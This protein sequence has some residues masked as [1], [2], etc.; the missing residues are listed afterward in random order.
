MLEQQCSE[1]LFAM[2]T[3]VAVMFGFF[4]CFLFSRGSRSSESKY[5]LCTFLKTYQNENV[6]NPCLFPCFVK[7]P[8][9]GWCCVLI[10]RF[11]QP[12]DSFNDHVTHAGSI[13]FCITAV[14]VPYSLWYCVYNTCIFY[15]NSCIW[16]KIRSVNVSVSICCLCVFTLIPLKNIGNYSYSIQHQWAKLV[17]KTAITLINIWKK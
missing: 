1:Q 15:Y 9:P 16:V 6:K 5:I 11:S 4:S 17:R 14:V 13:I 3:V 12:K 2:I 8:S 7:T 10:W